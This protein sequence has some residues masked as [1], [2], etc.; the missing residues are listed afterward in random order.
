MFYLNLYVNKSNE[1]NLYLTKPSQAK[2]ALSLAQLSPSLLDFT[3]KT[4]ILGK[5]G[6]GPIINWLN[7]RLKTC[8]FMLKKLFSYKYGTG[9]TTAQK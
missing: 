4:F 6:T 8:I 9:S 1:A 3:L 2:L 7:F 5:Y